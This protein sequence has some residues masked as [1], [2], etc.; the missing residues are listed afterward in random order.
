MH[1]D[2]QTNFFC[3][4]YANRNVL[5]ASGMTAA[6]V[7][8]KRKNGHLAVCG[9]AAISDGPPPMGDVAPC[10][11]GKPLGEPNMECESGAPGD[12]GVPGQPEG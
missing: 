2:R 4:G 3:V 1:T 9:E 6:F 7:A 10:I 5:S 8:T 11:M 12:V